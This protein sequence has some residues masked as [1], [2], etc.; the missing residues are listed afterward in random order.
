M[1]CA[2]QNGPSPELLPTAHG[3]N[4]SRYR[5]RLP[6]ASPLRVAQSSV[7]ISPIQPRKLP[8]DLNQVRHVAHVPP[9]LSLDGARSESEKR[10]PNQFLV[11]IVAFFSSGQV[12]RASW[13]GPVAALVSCELR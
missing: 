11:F 9:C 12:A 3:S 2:E 7:I 8:D 6:A 4:R 1:S 13:I 10:G 5:A